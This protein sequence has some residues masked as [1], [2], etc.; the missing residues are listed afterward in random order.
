MEQTNPSVYL[1]LAWINYVISFG[2]SVITLSNI[3]LFFSIVS[4][5]VYIW[6]TISKHLRDKNQNNQTKT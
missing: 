6:V 4:S 5:I 1:F 3:S 2:F